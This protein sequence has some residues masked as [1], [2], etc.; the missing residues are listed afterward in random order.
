M[1]AAGGTAGHVLPALAVADALSRRGVSVTFA[2]SPDRVEAEL[3]PKAGYE[4]DSFRVSGLPRR[5]GPALVRALALAGRAP[6][7]CIRI[8]RRRRP[9]VVLGAGGYVA[10]PVVLAAGILRIRAAL[11]EA[12]AYLGLAN[13][14]ATPFATR[15]FLSFPID[16]LEG[17]RY[18]VVGRP[19]PARARAIDR[20]EARSRFGLPH[21]GPVVLVVGG[22]QGARA[23]NEA[24]VDAFAEGGPAVLH[25]C[26][27]A[28]YDH[29]R[30]RVARD[31]YVLVA[32]TD[33]IG[34][35][36]GAADLVVARA[37]GSVWEIAAAGTPAL[38]VPY[39]FATADHQAKNA[40]YFEERGGAIVVR[41][42]DL[43]L[44]RDVD[45]LLADGDRLKRMGDA[46]ERVA[47]PDAA[48]EIAEEMIALASRS[49]GGGGGSARSDAQRG[50]SVGPESPRPQST[51]RTAGSGEAGLRSA[52][53]GGDEEHEMPPLAGR[54]VWFV[55][56]GGAGLSAYA[57]VARAWG[58]AVSGWDKNETP[59]LVHVHAAGIPVVVAP[60][61]SSPPDEAEVVVSTAYAGRV[62]GK[63]RAAFLGELTR[64]A[65]TIV[66]SG[67]HGKTTTAGMIAYCLDRLGHDP[68]F[69]I[70]GE[71]PQLGGHARAGA[72]WFVVEGDESDR[73][74]ASLAADIA[75]IT[76]VDLDHHTT[77]SSLAEVEDLYAEWLERIPDAAVIRGEELEPV[78]FELAVPGEHNRR[79]AAS[80]L[81][82][83][84]HAGVSPEEAAPVLAGF[85]GAGRRL[86]ARG[87][88]SGVRVFDDYAHHPAEVEATLT[89]ARGLA[90]GGRLVVLFQPHL[91]SRTLHVERELAA[92]LARADVACVTEIYP[93][94]EEPLPG[95]SGKMIV[96]GL[97]ELRPGMPVGWA[98]VLEDAAALVASHARDG[99][100]VL[101]VGAGDVDRVV[102]VILERL[103]G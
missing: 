64:L 37:G 25:L 36:L 87:E 27:Q 99:D 72:G 56:I 20:E 1:I 8:L 102:P 21:E 81:A 40:R 50:D 76:N 61:P 77:F 58:A 55:G 47:K 6:V 22:S 14:L 70:G 96:D 78:A 83:L 17:D 46:M 2:G 35:A 13:R 44:R 71:I 95:V 84:A 33:E 98:P 42:A 23:L 34:A 86:E 91:Y 28:H 15:V 54:K 66:V 11:T 65:R 12:D 49:R 57:I 30:G 48:E 41:E 69:A 63:T 74:V 79:N 10:G 29:L 3:V 26:G 94:R 7:A 73:T 68:S 100:V 62:A 18:R 97:C 5:A 4:F 103:K 38:L 9:D 88:T 19:I 93:A 52:R 89:A 53:A 24:A 45:A 90:D 16:G 75:V 31:D 101:T 60:E 82:A 39:P 92:A 43:D 32:F 67:A 85:G 51:R 59:Y 80:A